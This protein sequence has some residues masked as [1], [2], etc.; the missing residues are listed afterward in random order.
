MDNLIIWS[1]TDTVQALRHFTRP[2]PSTQGGNNFSAM[3]AQPG[4]GQSGNNPLDENSNQKAAV[5][6]VNWSHDQTLLAAAIG[7]QVAIFDLQKLQ[8]RQSERQ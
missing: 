7:D 8:I 1:L 5:S 4:S 2:Y 3:G 6:A